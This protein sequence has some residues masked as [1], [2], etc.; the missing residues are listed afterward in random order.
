MIDRDSL[1]ENN[2]MSVCNTYVTIPSK[3]QCFQRLELLQALIET[4]QEII[5]L[6]GLSQRIGLS[7][8]K[9]ISYFKRNQPSVQTGGFLFANRSWD[10][11]LK[12]ESYSVLNNCNNTTSLFC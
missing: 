8:S 7:F 10:L 12:E 3:T 6:L 4:I 2:V 5:T 9:R 11:L 1:D